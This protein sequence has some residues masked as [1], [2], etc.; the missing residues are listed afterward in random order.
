ML[1]SSPSSL[2]V[3]L[4]DDEDWSGVRRKLTPLKV[5]VMEVLSSAAA[6][7]GA[8]ADGA[9]TAAAMGPS[10]ILEGMAEW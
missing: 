4:D 1:A 6:D 10:D 8:G 7:A 2:L 3:M 5:R 9:P